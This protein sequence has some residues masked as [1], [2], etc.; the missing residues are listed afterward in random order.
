[1]DISMFVIL[2]MLRFGVVVKVESTYC[3]N[4]CLV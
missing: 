4:F 3:V 1:M 2:K